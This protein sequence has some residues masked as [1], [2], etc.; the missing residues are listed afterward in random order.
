MTYQHR[1]RIQA[2]GDR[3]QKSVTWGQDTPLTLAEGLALLD[4]LYAQLSPAERESR[5]GAF[6]QVEQWMIR[7]YEAKGLDAVVSDSFPKPNKSKTGIRIDIEIL[8]GS[9]FVSGR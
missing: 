3:L 8:S 5:R 7:A 4:K 2:Q 1:G 9:A 6:S